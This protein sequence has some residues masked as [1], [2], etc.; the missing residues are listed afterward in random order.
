MDASKTRSVLLQQ[1][2][3][4]V[5]CRSKAKAPKDDKKR[6]AKKKKKKKKKKK[7]ELY[8]EEYE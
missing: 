7:E 8:A 5:N 6:L 4:P 2:V 3:R 1:T